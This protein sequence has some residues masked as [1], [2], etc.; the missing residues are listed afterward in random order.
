M[1]EEEAT[2]DEWP[3]EGT[4]CLWVTKIEVQPN[5]YKPIRGSKSMEAGGDLAQSSRRPSLIAFCRGLVPCMFV[6]NP[7]PRSCLPESP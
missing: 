3:R 6:L 5:Q 7:S 4:K 2:E 1:I